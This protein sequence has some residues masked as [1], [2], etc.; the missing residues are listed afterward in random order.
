MQEG[1]DFWGYNPSVGNLSYS[2]SSPRKPSGNLA[3][4]QIWAWKRKCT[5]SPGRTP[6]KKGRSHYKPPTNP[7]KQNRF[8]FFKDRKNQE[9][10]EEGDDIAE[11][12]EDTEQQV[13]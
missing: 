7:N 9:L 8:N 2:P 3:R 6:P 11:T 10:Q 13:E 1:S 4:R 12:S 5:F